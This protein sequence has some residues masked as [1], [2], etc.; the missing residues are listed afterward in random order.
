MQEFFLTSFA[1]KHT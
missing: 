1:F